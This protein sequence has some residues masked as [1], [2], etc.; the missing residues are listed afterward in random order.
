MDWR[1]LGGKRM[2]EETATQRART[3]LRRQTFLR[4][5]R[6]DGPGDEPRLAP[7]HVLA[8]ALWFSVATGLIELAGEQLRGW[9][10]GPTIWLGRHQLHRHYLWM[11][12]ATDALVF[13]ACGLALAILGT[14]RPRRAVWLSCI[15]FCFLSLL[16]LLMLFRWLAPVACLA[17]AAGL[18]SR[19][20]P[21]VIANLPRF[22]RFVLRSL[23]A[24]LLVVTGLTAFSFAREGWSE[25]RALASRPPLPSDAPNVLLVVLDATRADALTPY[26]AKRE[27]TP[28]LD[29]LAKHGVTFDHARA[30]APWT[31][32]SHASLFTGRWPHELGVGPARPLDRT[33]PT[34]A[35]CLRRRG[36]A[37]AG[38]AG[39]YAFCGAHYGLNRGFAHYDDRPI[40]LDDMLGCNALGRRIMPAVEWARNW[41]SRTVEHTEPFNPVDPAYATRQRN[42]E[43]INVAF[44]TWLSTQKGRPF[45]AFLNYYDAHA[46]YVPPR[47]WNQHFG[48]V[49]ATRDEYQTLSDWET[50]W[51][52]L[53]P[54]NRRR[55][56][57]PSADDLALAR[58]CYDDSI[59]YM[60]HQLNRLLQALERR[61][62]R[63]NTLVIV[64]ADHGEGFGEHNLYCHFLSV[65]R[66][67]VDVPLIV[68]W[69][70]HVPEGQRI[71]APVSL[72]S[73]PA[74]VMDM[75]RPGERSP[76]PGQSLAGLWNGAGTHA[77]DEPVLS[78][79]E[80]RE[81]LSVHA[82]LT[83]TK[84]YIR[85]ANGVEQ[86]FDIKDDP[87]EDNDLM[88]YP[89]RRA[90]AAPFRAR[91]QSLLTGSA[92]LESGVRR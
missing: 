18:T 66:P 85:H 53:N 59:A 27:T 78:E 28:H 91:L 24:L 82:L 32:P 45:F 65:H 76:F 55:G 2:T 3:G 39:N 67:E 14:M 90:E 20:G 36:Y 6:P 54:D 68:S 52:V 10:Y 1:G 71:D 16:T 50:D 88:G 22:R 26:G 5:P 38:F 87:R 46:P 74:T 40:S 83:G 25:Q 23:P 75:A 72:R 7:L 77:G 60:D 56:P 51:Q 70:G 69:P 48:R 21:R 64:T 4:R 8:I 43:E 73:V 42:A 29:E 17:L 81:E 86:L 58:D 9:I 35:E 41:W 79:L 13:G 31:L 47:T 57:N 49:P 12:P 80:E 19:V 63:K 33:Y 11:I 62:L 34:L 37:T 61:G 84:V 89:G 15:V 30:A 44:L 92:S